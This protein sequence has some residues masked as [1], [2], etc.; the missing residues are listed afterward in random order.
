MSTPKRRVAWKPDPPKKASRAP[1]PV[2]A[3]VEPAREVFAQRAGVVMDRETWRQAVGDR[4]AE[5]AEPGWIKNSVL[6]VIVASAAWGQELSLLSGEVRKR[7]E[8]FGIRVQGIRFLVKDGAGFRR[9]GERRRPGVRQALPPDLERQLKDVGDAELAATIAE[10][11]EYSLGRTSAS[12]PVSERPGAPGP[13]GAGARSARSGRAGGR[14][15][16]GS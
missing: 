8:A 11:A 4:I 3:L 10:A 1:T 16:A 2:G 6:T 9:A 5:R 15:P 7:L 13:R 14:G 12:P